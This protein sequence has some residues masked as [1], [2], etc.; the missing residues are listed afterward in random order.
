MLKERLSHIP[1]RE[2]SKKQE[3]L[4]EWAAMYEVP[5]HEAL[6]TKA[7]AR[8][9]RSKARWDAKIAERI[10]MNRQ[11]KKSAKVKTDAKDTNTLAKRILAALNGEDVEAK[12]QAAQMIVHIPDDGRQS[13]RDVLRDDIIKGLLSDNQ[14]VRLAMV[15]MIPYADV[16][17]RLPLIHM[18]LENDDLV[19]RI[20]AV[21]KIMATRIT[22]SYKLMRIALE[23]THPDV[24]AEAATLLKD[25]TEGGYSFISKA[26][27]DENDL[28]QVRGAAAIKELT[29]RGTHID[30]LLLIVGRKARGW[31]MSENEEVK[32]GGASAIRYAPETERAEL[33]QM[34]MQNDELD[35]R[36]EAVRAIQYLSEHERSK[37]VAMALD[38][39]DPSIQAE[40][41]LSISFLL[42]HEQIDFVKKALEIRNRQVDLN[43]VELLTYLPNKN[44][45]LVID[46]L[47]KRGMS[48]ILIAPP[49]YKHDTFDTEGFSM[50]SFEKTGSRT[51]LLGGDFKGNVIIRH[52]EPE[53][54]VI[55]QKVFEDYKIWQE[56]GFD[57][58]PIEPIISYRLSEQGTVDVMSGVLDVNL[59]TWKERD[60]DFISELLD[61]RNRILTVLR[62]QNIHHGH[63][64]P[65]NFCLRFFRDP[66]GKVDFTKKP[67]IYIIDFDQAVS[68]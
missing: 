4:P 8:Y 34:A 20:N 58:V 41:V 37:Y 48:D 3:Q 21:K 17:A 36:V 52:I 49:L 43:V 61:E 25:L 22:A 14:D 66:S 11:E 28:V 53:S 33:V 27:D 46:L 55:W 12:V 32:F 7:F 1:N 10:E 59:T 16:D 44:K 5:G 47:K 30:N 65:R 39:S 56:A 63:D 19:V 40:A 18:A 23:N 42:E 24:R 45:S 38:A 13:L 57:Y 67:R 50:T 29:Y 64:H 51:T 9:E 62:K 6:G 54:F 2:I 26:L 35:V 31:L 60:G 15:E 68:K